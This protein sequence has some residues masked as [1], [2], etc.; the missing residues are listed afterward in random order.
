MFIKEVKI[1][2]N[3]YFWN[4]KFNALWLYLHTIYP[5]WTDNLQ[6]KLLSTWLDWKL[7]WKL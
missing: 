7:E 2:E 3:T 1:W 6:L 5:M 4:L